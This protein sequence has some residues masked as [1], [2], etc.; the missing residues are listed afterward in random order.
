MSAAAAPADSKR[1]FLV[2]VDDTPECRLALRYAARRAL[3]TRGAVTLLY[4]ISPQDFQHFL[5]VEQIMR[6]EARQEAEHVLHIL[7]EEINSIAGLMPELVIREG[8][9]KDEV[10]ALIEEDPSIRI[11]V[12]G[13]GTGKDGPGPLVSALAGQM[14]G[15]LSIPIT[16]VPGRL[17][18]DRIDELT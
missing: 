15:S 4:V 13:A 12:L 7:A 8:D 10:L 3:K 9:R 5:G 11:L 18:A 2:V 1:K 17:D 16:I 6:Q 14:S